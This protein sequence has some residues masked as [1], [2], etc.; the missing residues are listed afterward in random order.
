MLKVVRALDQKGFSDIEIIGIIG[1]LGLANQLF[2]VQGLIKTLA[3]Q[4]ADKVLEAIPEI[5]NVKFQIKGN[6]IVVEYHWKP[7]TK[8]DYSVA[9][10]FG[11]A[12]TNSAQKQ[13]NVSI[14]S[15]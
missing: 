11:I 1:G 12:N 15:S 2:D 10:I 13:L 4:V 3:T 9:G 7:K 8:N 14:D 5:P 6:E